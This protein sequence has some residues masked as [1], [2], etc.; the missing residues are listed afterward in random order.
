MLII[1]LSQNHL[2][3]KLILG[4]SL[5][6]NLIKVFKVKERHKDKSN[7]LRSSCMDDEKLLEKY[8]ATW[9][10]IEDLRNVELNA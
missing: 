4:I 2:K 3:Q 6:Q 1:P 5:K 7:K 9:T 10:Q 8:K